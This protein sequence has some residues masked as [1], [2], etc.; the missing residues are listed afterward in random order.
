MLTALLTHFMLFA[1]PPR[2][3]DTLI[4]VG[5]NCFHWGLN[6]EAN[7]WA[8]KPIQSCRQSC[9]ALIRF[10]CMASH[11]YKLLSAWVIFERQS[12]EILQL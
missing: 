12:W 2:I 11:L 3:S 4:Q 5:L 6:L 1:S 9:Q 7:C 8:S 10:T